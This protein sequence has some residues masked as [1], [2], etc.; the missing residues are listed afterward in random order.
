MKH[1]VEKLKNNEFVSFNPRG[2]SMTPKI[3]SGDLVTI[4]R[5]TNDDKLKL[6]KGNIVFCKVKS[7]Y[8]L[9]LIIS[10][11]SDQVLIGNNHGNINGWT[12]LDNIFAI[13]V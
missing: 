12:G 13:K 11:K 1:I 2:N 10:V 7:N 5:L 3:K 9:H 6:K 8:Y 4:Q